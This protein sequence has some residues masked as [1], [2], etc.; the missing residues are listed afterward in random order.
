MWINYLQTDA[1]DKHEP[2]L[3]KQ[4]HAWQPHKTPARAKQNLK[5]TLEIPLIL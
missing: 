3:A 1:V 5:K 4:K 2:Q